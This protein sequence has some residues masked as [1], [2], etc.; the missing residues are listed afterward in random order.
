[1]SYNIHAWRCS[2]HRDNY[3]RVLDCVKRVDP[4]VLC[5]NEVLHPF[6]APSKEDGADEYYEA[7]K[8]Q[9]GHG[10]P[11]PSS[12]EPRLLEDSNLARLAASTGLSNW[13]FRAATDEGFFGK[14]P[15]GNAILSRYPIDKCIHVPLEVEPGDVTLG[16]QPRDFVDPRL[17]SAATVVL[18]KDDDAGGGGGGDGG[19][20]G[21]ETARL[22]VCFAHLDQKS[23][24]LREKQML[25]ALAS[26]EEHMAAAD[27]DDGTPHVFCGDWN[28]FQ[29]SDCSA[30]GW[31]AIRDLYSS[32]GWPEPRE[33]SL[34]LDALSEANYE[35][36]F[37]RVN[38]EVAP[39]T[40]QPS[41]SCDGLE[42]A[43]GNVRRGE[44]PG[45][46]CWTK[47]PLSVMRID[48]I[49][50]SPPKAAAKFRIKPHQYS[51]VIVDASDH[52]PIFADLDLLPI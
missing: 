45:P 8:N 25:R 10:I 51:R 29:R 38:A 35:D 2:D 17:F 28:T 50:T 24:E 30:A 31:K 5:L 20:K 27:D 39:G 6:V 43:D 33:R 1:M 26:M 37:Y 4:D 3:D 32:R 7:V 18:P 44:F 52:F 49:Q 19:G 36:A 47:D 13:E 21:R 23:E 40:L 11:L 34:V 46:T 9:C 14:V 12:S 22:G 48:H 41:S 15:F 42:P 16:E